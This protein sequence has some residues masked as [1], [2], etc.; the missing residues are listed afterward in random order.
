MRKVQDVIGLPVL[1]T[2]SGKRIGN[3][4]DVLF[5]VNGEV[6]G[7]SVETQGLFAKTL[8][9][10]FENIGAIGPDAVTVGTDRFLTSTDD[11]NLGY[12]LYIGKKPYKG[13]PIVAT[14][15][16]E[17]GHIEDVYFLEEMGKIIGYELSD[18]FFQ[19]V[20]EG[21]KII[22]HPTSIVI[23]EDAMI[24]PYDEI[25]EISPEV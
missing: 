20:T 22:E 14:N 23:G 19:D 7:L 15:G 6:M 3:V 13:L 17:F 9:L 5:Q 16:N 8:F 21:R 2:S 25:K 12:G 4:K 1:D 11:N 18:G 10:S 24:V